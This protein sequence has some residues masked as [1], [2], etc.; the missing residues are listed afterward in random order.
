MTLVSW[1]TATLRYCNKY[2]GFFSQRYIPIYIFQYL[3]ESFPDV[4]NARRNVTH[5]FFVLISYPFRSHPSYT[6]HIQHIH[7]SAN[8][9]DNKQQPL[10]LARNVDF[11]GNPYND[12]SQMPDPVILREK[13]ED[14]ARMSLSSRMSCYGRFGNE[15]TQTSHEGSVDSAPLGTPTRSCKDEGYESSVPD[16]DSDDEGASGRPEQQCKEMEKKANIMLLAEQELDEL[17]GLSVSD[18]DSGGNA[19]TNDVRFGMKTFAAV[20]GLAEELERWSKSA[21]D[22]RSQMEEAIAEARQ[23]NKEMD[24]WYQSNKSAIDMTDVH[25]YWGIDGMDEE[26]ESDD[27]EEENEETSVS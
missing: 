5:P 20:K 13:L 7:K 3:I 14:L 16:V 15:E 10:V 27:E 2:L 18:I 9:Q 19:G 17:C 25:L 8:M 23:R 11:A 12:L 21:N 22:M 6:S 26:V 4:L 1:T 24:L